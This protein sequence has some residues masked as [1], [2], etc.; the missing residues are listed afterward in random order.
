[1]QSKLRVKMHLQDTSSRSFHWFDE[2][3]TRSMPQSH[4]LHTLWRVSKVQSRPWTGARGRGLE[5]RW[6]AG[7]ALSL[8][9]KPH[10]HYSDEHREVEQEEHRQ[11][12]EDHCFLVWYM[13]VGVG[14]PCD[15]K[16]EDSFNPF[17]PS[18]LTHLLFLKLSH[19]S[20]VV[21]KLFRSKNDVLV[22][23]LLEDALEHFVE[24][25]SAFPEQGS[26]K[27]DLT[28]LRLKNQWNRRE[29][30]SADQI[31]QR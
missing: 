22:F 24:K 30:T 20:V 17:G 18:F 31:I 2:R 8:D 10:H 19:F 26:L 7:S 14:W 4:L 9:H 12:E 27:V 1:M 23:A 11:E 25:L 6:A 16:K 28:Y 21:F 3:S 15:Q 29:E 13:D 5:S